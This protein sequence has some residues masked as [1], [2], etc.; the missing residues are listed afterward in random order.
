MPRGGSITIELQNVE[1]DET[2][3]QKHPDSRPGPHI[4]LAVTD[5]GSGMDQATMTRI[6]EPFFSTKG[7]KGT[8]LGLATLHGIVKQNGGHVSVYSEVGHGTTF[9]IYLP[10]VEQR[11]LSS[12]S[13][14]GPPPRS[15]GNETVL[16]VEDEEGVRALSRHILQSCGYTL[17]EAHDGVEAVRVAERH[18]GRIDLLLTDVVMPRMSGREV[19]ERVTGLH[20]ETKVLFLSGYTDDAVVR[21]GILEAEVAFLQKPFLPTSLAAKVRAVLDGG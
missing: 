17:L 14:H 5:T 15:R 10:R 4:L 13:Q 12:R 1:L 9:K 20:P 19:A 3:I 21:H 18:R 7:D 6:F 16:L 2:Y 8:G 11:P